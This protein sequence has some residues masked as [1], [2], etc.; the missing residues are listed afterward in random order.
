MAIFDFKCEKCNEVIEHF[1]LASEEVPETL[2]CSSCGHTMKRQTGAA[3]A[4]FV[5]KG[6]PSKDIKQRRK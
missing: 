2:I 3:S 1:F 4:H 6:W 5:G